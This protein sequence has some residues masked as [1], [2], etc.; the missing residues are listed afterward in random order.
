M[1]NI[2]IQQLKIYADNTF[3]ILITG[4]KGT[5]K[6][7][8]I[9]NSLEN[10]VFLSCSQI[11]NNFKETLKQ[12]LKKANEKNL[13]FD[14]IENLSI[15][16]QKILFECISTKNG[17]F[18]EIFENENIS[19]QLIFISNLSLTQLYNYEFYQPLVDRISQQI[20]ELTPLKK[21]KFETQKQA[22]KSVW[23]QMCFKDKKGQIM[24]YIEN[25]D[26]LNWLKT[27]HLA[28][29]FRD[30]EKIAILNWRFLTFSE[31]EKKIF[32]AKNEFEFVKQQ[33]QKS[34]AKPENDFFIYDEDADKIIK[35]FRK[36]L[37]AWAKKVYV[38]VPTILEKLSVSEKTLYNWENGK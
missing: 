13:I 27:L 18:F 2:E 4:E 10:I 19:C 30:L 5:G 32:E 25:T 31:D 24:D 14:N 22:Y 34:D 26:I 29:N 12:K 9:K 16:N 11:E 15:E 37:V 35:N 23:E 20:I 33:F 21:L 36:E 38:D 17:G 1:Y 8:L 28:G 6:S 7:F 3:S